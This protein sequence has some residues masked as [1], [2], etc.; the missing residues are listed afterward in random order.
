[1]FDILRKSTKN[2]DNKN[3]AMES[4]RLSLSEID[5]VRDEFILKLQTR[6]K[7]ISDPEK[8]K[9]LDFRKNSK[10]EYSDNIYLK[11][12]STDEQIRLGLNIFHVKI[13]KTTFSPAH[14]HEARSQ[15]IFII[16]GSVYDSIAKMRFETG[17]SFFISKR[18]KHSIKYIK[19]SEILFIYMPSLKIVDD[20]KN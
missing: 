15:V 9:P 18:N 19:G 13:D 5:N 3:E 10:L 6:K 16:K 14:F 12:L 20:E 2:T 11:D 7:Y 8:C 1:M 17:E 4:L